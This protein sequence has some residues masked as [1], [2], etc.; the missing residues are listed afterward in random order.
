MSYYSFDHLRNLLNC[1]SQL[2]LLHEGEVKWLLPNNCQ[3]NYT[4]LDGWRPYLKR[5]KVKWFVFK[6]LYR[7]GLSNYIPNVIVKKVNIKQCEDI[8][9][10]TKN[11]GN[12]YCGAMY[13]GKFSKYQKAIAFI[14]SDEHKLPVKVIK[15]PLTK[16]SQQSI[17]NEAC[18]LDQVQ[19][20]NPSIIS[21]TSE[22]V[23]ERGAFS[24]NYF[25]GKSYSLNMDN[26]LIELLTS[27]QVSSKEFSVFNMIN[28]LLVSI[29]KHSF[30][31]DSTKKILTLKLTSKLNNEHLPYVIQHGDLAPWNIL[32]TKS[33]T[34]L[35]DW[36]FG[37]LDGMPLFDIFNFFF[38]VQYLFPNKSLDFHSSQN[39]KL[40]IRYL[41]TLGIDPSMHEVLKIIFIIKKIIFLA[42]TDNNQCNYLL[43]FI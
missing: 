39:S 9:F 4:A 12:L 30:I 42:D 40:N 8:N 11:L 41:R 43:R 37:C 3:K 5:S 33:K 22:Q 31:S 2:S 1:T 28:D 36:E 20:L 29:S 32:Y 17:K 23:T 6:K 35:I 15:L 10:L 14:F 27:L 13:I 18:I 24:Q 21:G 25:S 26:A 38:T 7:L 19:K 34:C 16:G